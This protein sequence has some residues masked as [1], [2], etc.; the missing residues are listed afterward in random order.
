M[1]KSKNAAKA[2][3]VKSGVKAE[4]E[5]IRVDRSSAR[6]TLLGVPDV[7]G[8]A[9]KV[10][11]P[12]AER[13]IGVEMIVQNSM[14]GGMTDIGFLVKKEF[15]DIAI[16]ITRDVAQEIEAQGVSFSTEIALVS[17]MGKGL[18]EDTSMSAGMFKTL[19]EASVN[20]EMI[21]SSSRFITCVVGAEKAEKAANALKAAYL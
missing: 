17:L 10:F 21:V 18:A 4:I 1:S 16:S 14:R 12:L 11:S 6:I 15:L 19:A 2:A 7:P 20:I 3:L 8:V 5:D 13:G 9:A